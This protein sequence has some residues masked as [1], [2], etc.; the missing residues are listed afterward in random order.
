MS[1]R[2]TIEQFIRCKTCQL[3]K[4]QKSNSSGKFAI[5]QKKLCL[6]N[7]SYNW[8][9]KPNIHPNSFLWLFLSWRA[10]PKMWFLEDIIISK[11]K[12]ELWAEFNSHA[13]Q[14]VPSDRPHQKFCVISVWCKVVTHFW[15]CH[16][17][18]RVASGCRTC[19]RPGK[20]IAPVLSSSPSFWLTE[21]QFAWCTYT[22]PLQENTRNK[23]IKDFFRL[24]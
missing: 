11:Y 4:E 7:R 9:S 14:I 10:T 20:R 17:F 5:N 6:T 24:L 12:Y 22:S 16:V 21:C 13:I 23:F 3:F 1:Q 15:P 19:A 18:W 8:W 2:L